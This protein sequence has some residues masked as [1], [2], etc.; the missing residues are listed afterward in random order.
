L[1]EPEQ[2]HH[3]QEDAEVVENGAI[4]KPTVWTEVAFTEQAI[5]KQA[6]R[7]TSALA[8]RG[9]IGVWLAET[10]KSELEYLMHST[11]RNLHDSSTIVINEVTG[12]IMQ[13][14]K[15]HFLQSLKKVMLYGNGLTQHVRVNTLG[16]WN[17]PKQRAHC[18]QLQGLQKDKR[19]RQVQV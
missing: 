10:L 6:Q 11:Q 7:G 8:T 2:G 9:L 5:C 1:I 18:W 14:C 15:T 19:P 12:L 13:N 3:R 17:R 16:L 4:Q